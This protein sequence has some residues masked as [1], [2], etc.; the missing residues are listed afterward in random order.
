MSTISVAG[1]HNREGVTLDSLLR[2][3]AQFQTRQ[4]LAGAFSALTDSSGGTASG[5]RTV[6]GVAPTLVNVA[7]SATN[8]ADKTTAE[9]AFVAVQD[10]VRELFTRATAI[11]A[12]LVGGSGAPIPAITYNGGGAAADGTISAI[13]VAVT[14]AVTGIQ[15]APTN[16]LITA[17][18]E[19]FYVL[20]NLTN[21]LCVASGRPLL[22]LGSNLTNW[23][24]TIPA[25]V[26]SLGTAA[27][28]GVTKAAVDAALAQYRTNVATIA[29][30]LNDLRIITQP[31][32]VAVP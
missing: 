6:A 27:D 23:K 9:A 3:M 14:A 19:A 13:S 11:Q 31:P 22:V 7:N 12:N 17:L 10:A 15:A 1:N 28:P 5:T 4:A 16:T 32:V 25:F 26:T 18:N 30:R 2:E 21:H 8:L 24:T 29:A 20:A